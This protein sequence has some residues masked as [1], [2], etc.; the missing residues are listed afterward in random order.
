MLDS[1]RAQV[2][3]QPRASLAETPTDVKHES[4][5]VRTSKHFQTINPKVQLPQRE[6]LQPPPTKPANTLKGLPE[7]GHR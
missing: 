4:L 7:D 6:Q 1:G 3:N 2:K 5:K